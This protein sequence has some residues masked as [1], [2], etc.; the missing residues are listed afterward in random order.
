MIDSGL[1]LYRGF[2]FKLGLIIDMRDATAIMSNKMNFGQGA[3]IKAYDP[4]GL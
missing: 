3:N 1:S 4:K 2:S